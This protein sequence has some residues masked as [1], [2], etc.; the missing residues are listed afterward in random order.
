MSIEVGHVDKW[1][2][3]VQPS[4]LPKTI[5]EYIAQYRPKVV[6]TYVDEQLNKE[7][8]VFEPRYC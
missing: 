1:N 7:V 6:R 2:G 4:E 3:G 5:D 8:K